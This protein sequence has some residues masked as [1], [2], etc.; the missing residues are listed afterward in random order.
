[1]VHSVSRGAGPGDMTCSCNE[2]GVRLFTY[3]SMHRTHLSDVVMKWA[4]ADVFLGSKSVRSG[5]VVVMCHL[6]S[7]PRI[8]LSLEAAAPERKNQHAPWSS[9]CKQ[10]R[11]GPLRRYVFISIIHRFYIHIINRRIIN[12]YIDVLF[13][14]VAS[15]VG[16]ESSVYL[17]GSGARTLWHLPSFVMNLIINSVLSVLLYLHSVVVCT[18]SVD[19]RAVRTKLF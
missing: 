2:I 7:T 10:L 6:S 14:V 17:Y 16:E 8:C 9:L 18:T 5:S 11:G 4:V 12:M 15:L 13:Q 3:Y 1:M 19:I